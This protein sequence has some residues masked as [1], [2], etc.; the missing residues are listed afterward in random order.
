MKYF[1]Y[2]LSRISLV[3][4]SAFFLTLGA[5]D[6]NKSYSEMLQEE[7]HAVNWFLAKQQVET[8]FPGEGFKYGEDAPY[9]RMNADGS[10][11]MKVLDP[12][13]MEDCPEKGE[14]VYFRFMRMNIKNYYDFGTES[15]AGNADNM[16]SSLNA[17]SL[18]YGNKTYSST[19][20]HGTGLQVPLD[21][22]GYN[23]HVMLVVKS[24]EGRSGDISSCIP[25]VYNI[26]YFKAEY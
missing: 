25:Y 23:C 16:D 12:G 9:Y 8:K 22:L 1:N 7:E 15:W 24:I 13:D 26:R 20:Q 21:Y 19:T 11:Y 3:V 4:V 14:T 6:D 2:I 5:C 17:T 18:V 10:V